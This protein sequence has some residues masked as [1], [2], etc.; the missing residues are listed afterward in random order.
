MENESLTNELKT[1]REAN[2]KLKS[3]IK[4]NKT[5]AQEALKAVSTNNTLGNLQF[6]DNTNTRSSTGPDDPSE[7]RP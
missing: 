6:A 5:I 3:E 4:T 1:V 7:K 2:L